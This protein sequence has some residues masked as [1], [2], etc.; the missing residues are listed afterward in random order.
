MTADAN[1]DREQS[2]EFGE[3]DTK[4]TDHE[5]PATTADYSTRTAIMHSTF[6]RERGPSAKC[7][8]LSEKETMKPSPDQH[9]CRT[10]QPKKSVR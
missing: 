4:L 8:A 7:S 6:R 5:Y 9:R 2:I 1:K 10:N 3:L